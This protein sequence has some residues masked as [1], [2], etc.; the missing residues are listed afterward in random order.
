M[1]QP[2]FCLYSKY[3]FL[4]QGSRFLFWKMRANLK[5]FY[6]VYSVHCTL[7]TCDTW[8]AAAFFFTVH[9]AGIFFVLP[10]IE[11]YQKVDLRTI[12]LDVPP[13]EVM[14]IEAKMAVKN[15]SKM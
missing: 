5:S 2:L 6:C 7:Y 15:R 13:Q 10:C 12:T 9:C 8:H 4:Q 11:T 14:Y 3:I 1:M